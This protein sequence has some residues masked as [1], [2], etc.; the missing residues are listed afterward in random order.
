MVWYIITDHKWFM[1]F[2]SVLKY[3]EPKIFYLKMSG[4][5]NN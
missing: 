1:R 4:Y 3:P 5:R 2:D